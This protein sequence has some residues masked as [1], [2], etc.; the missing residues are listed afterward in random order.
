MGINPPVLSG[1]EFGE[2][3]GG[4]MMKFIMPDDPNSVEPTIPP[5]SEEMFDML[6]TFGAPQKI[7]DAAC[8]IVEE[9]AEKYLNLADEVQPPTSEP[10][11]EPEKKRYQAVGYDNHRNVV[12]W[13]TYEKV[14]RHISWSDFCSGKYDAPWRDP[15]PEPTPEKSPKSGA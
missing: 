4:E 13:D 15:I 7:I 8:K 3:E 14:E 12:V 11:S 6:E 2:N 1:V 5:E 10:P 9:T